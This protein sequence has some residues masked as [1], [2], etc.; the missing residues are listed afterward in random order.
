MK[1]LADLVR[2][3]R[4]EEVI[5][6]VHIAGEGGI[7]KKLTSSGYIPNLIFYGPSGTGKT[8]IANILAGLSNRKIHKLNATEA[9]TADVRQV[10]ASLGTLEGSN[11]ILLYLDE[12]QNFNKKQQQ[13]ILKYIESGD[14]TLITS[15]TENPYFTI[16][17]A[18][19]SRSTILEFKQLDASDI[20]A[21]LLRAIDIVQEEFFVHPLTYEDEALTYIANM[22]SGDLRRALNFLELALYPNTKAKNFVLTIELAK[23]CTQTAGFAYDKFGDAHYDTLSAFQKSIRGSDVDASI[24]YLARLIKAGDLTSICRRLLVTAAEDIGLAYPQAITIVKSCTDAALQVGFPEASIPLAQ[25]VSLLALAP[26]SSASHQAI[27]AAL[28][29]LDN[30]GSLEIPMHLRDT[31]YGGASKLG[32]GDGYQYPHAFPNNHVTQ[33]Y[34]P[35][36]LA[37][38][39]Y[40]EPGTN[41][42]ERA[43]AEYWAKIKEQK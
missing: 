7:L 22:A 33:T 14:I 15:T 28:A 42:T 13:T 23:E 2:P 31:H 24:H 38:K 43:F 11:G 6:Q 34:L 17:G 27:G 1:P 8:T 5:G 16:F 26:K 30:M 9:N 29:D 4:L 20:K 35:T 10:I 3:L 21:G 32:R 12:I 25:A 39:K 40:Y 41:K 37:G 18:I 19:L 36:A